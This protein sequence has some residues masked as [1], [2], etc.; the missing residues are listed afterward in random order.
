MT[1]DLEIAL[2]IIAL[3]TVMAGLVFGIME[4]PRVRQARVDKGARD[5][6]STAVSPDD[7]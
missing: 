1:L 6:L 7:E 2:Q 3:G 4:V 5:V